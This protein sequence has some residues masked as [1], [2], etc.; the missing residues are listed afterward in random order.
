M[1]LSFVESLDL[2]CPYCG[3]PFQAETWLLVDGQ[4]RPELAARILDGTLH[5]L[6]CPHCGR[7]GQA[8]APLLY[9][10]GRSRRVLLAVPPGMAE[11][12]WRAAAETLLW[13]L[14]GAR[15]PGA[16]EPYLGELQAEAGLA[17]IAGVI[18]AE[19]LAGTAEVTS[20]E[21][22]P[23]IVVAI[24]ALLAAEGPDELRRALRQYP[25]L[26]EPR[27]ITMLRELAHE[28]FKQGEDE[29]GAGFSRAAEILTD[30]RD[31]S[32]N[33]V[34]RAPAASG[35]AAVGL[36]APEDPLDEL[37]FALLRCH[38][39][40]MLAEAVE[41]YPELLA[42]DLDDALMGWATRAR[43]AGK[44]RIAEGIDERLQAIR[45]MRERYQ[46]ERPVLEAVQAL[47]E[48]ETPEQLEQVL[49]EH[50]A[51]YSDGAEA[52]LDRLAASPDASFA[53]LVDERR[54]LLRRVRQLLRAQDDEGAS[55]L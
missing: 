43:A 32:L 5:D 15:P 14:I 36:E 17:G 35:R 28:A 53:A 45:V 18:R 20:D 22:T 6:H 16:R 34:V 8:P 52:A 37:A 30:V 49:L 33:D 50:D 38:S 26:V 23:P 41:R 46:S 47:L 42:G 31:L 12:E 40:D 54:A 7:L 19:G 1:P 55:L 25:L 44:A 13:T 11:P 2:S 51:L 24:Q 27:T 39:G 9:H 21:A 29:A 3:K 48:A 10:D 4:E